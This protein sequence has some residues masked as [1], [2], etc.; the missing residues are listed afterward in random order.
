MIGNLLNCLVIDVA[1]KFGRNGLDRLVTLGNYWLS[2]P[3]PF[4]EYAGTSV[5]GKCTLTPKSFEM[6]STDP[7]IN[8]GGIILFEFYKVAGHRIA[9]VR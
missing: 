8:N 1:F 7:L 5:A 6:H 2:H 4:L 3:E 9:L